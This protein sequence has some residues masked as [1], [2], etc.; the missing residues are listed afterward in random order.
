MWTSSVLKDMTFTVPGPDEGGIEIMMSLTR[1]Q[2][3]QVGGRTHA[4]VIQHRERHH[5]VS[6]WWLFQVCPDISSLSL[7]ET[8]L[9][10]STKVAQPE[11]P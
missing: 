9:A 11:N 6:S 8:T 4:T 3:G 7:N 1:M 2:E 10:Q 5:V